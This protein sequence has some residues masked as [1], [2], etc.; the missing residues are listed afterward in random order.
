MGTWGSLVLKFSRSHWLSN[1]KKTIGKDI[2]D[3]SN[4][5][6]VQNLHVVHDHKRVETTDLEELKAWE[7]I[8]SVC[9]GLLGNTAY[10]ITKPVLRRCYSLTRIWSTKCHSR[11]FFSISTS[12]FSRR[13]LEQRV[14]SMGKYLTNTLRR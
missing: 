4:A 7:A 8:K 5:A 3:V 10:Q 1:L 6:T 9:S 11:F 14:M 12:T 13:D 2:T